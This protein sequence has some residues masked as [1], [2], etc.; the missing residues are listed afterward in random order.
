MGVSYFTAGNPC[1]EISI[2]SRTRP[3]GTNCVNSEDRPRWTHCSPPTVGHGILPSTTL[4]YLLIPAYHHTYPNFCE[5]TI[6]SL[7]NSR[8]RFEL[9][10]FDLTNLF[11]CCASY[12]AICWNH[13]KCVIFISLVNCKYDMTSCPVSFT[14]YLDRHRG[15]TSRKVSFRWLQ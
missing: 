10:D 4:S 6:P 15:Q 1:Q 3:E 13:T 12:Q 11:K 8:Q 5:V 7:L 14:T 9:N 2:Q